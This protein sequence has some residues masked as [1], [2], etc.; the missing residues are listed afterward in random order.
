MQK[1]EISIQR[2]SSLKKLH[3]KAIHSKANS[4]QLPLSTMASTLSM[5]NPMSMFINNTPKQCRFVKC[6]IPGD[7]MKFVIGSQGYY[8]KVIT[9]QS[10]CAYIWY[11]KHLDM[12][13]VWGDSLHQVQNATDRLQKRM[14]HICT[15]MLTNNGML[16]DGK[17]VEKVM[18][19][20]MKDTECLA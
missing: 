12:I 13:E 20:D 8:F 10:G 7:W 17:R 14:M 19:G 2:F 1:I 11:H 16:K 3:Y 6:T 5:Y 18:W 9:Q 15:V 4:L